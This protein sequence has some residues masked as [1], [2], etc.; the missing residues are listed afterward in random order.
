VHSLTLRASGDGLLLGLRV[1][2]GAKQ[3]RVQGVYGDRL[4]VRVA[5]PPADNRANQL[6]LAALSDWLE[7]PSD[8]LAL[9]SGHTSRDKVV[10]VRGLGADELQK[11]LAT[12]VGKA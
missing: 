9:H 8:Y 1:S 10:L 3:T 6:L 11:R 2:P 5:A 4:K 12:L 7:L